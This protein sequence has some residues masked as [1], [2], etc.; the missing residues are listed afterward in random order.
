MKFAPHLG[1]SQW[2]QL[3]DYIRRRLV[4]L[5]HVERSGGAVV[6]DG[7][8]KT[9]GHT[10]KDLQAVSIAAM[11]ALVHETS[12]DYFTLFDKVLELVEN[13]RSGQQAQGEEDRAEKREA[14][15]QAAA[16]QAMETIAAI[17][18][19]VTPLVKGRGRPK[20]V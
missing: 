15:K 3:P 18:E 13:E 14:I 2:V 20:K 16:E 1:I 4:E 11:Q 6:E 9:D 10:E 7:K 12:E 8:L 19:A 5:F 17:S